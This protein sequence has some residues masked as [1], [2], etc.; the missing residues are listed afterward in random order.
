[1]NAIASAIGLI[2]ELLVTKPFERIASFFLWRDPGEA[3][4]DAAYK[5]NVEKLIARNKVRN[6]EP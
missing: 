3:Q 2:F 6:R 1:M 4:K 5:Q